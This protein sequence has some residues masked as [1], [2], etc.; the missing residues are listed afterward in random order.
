MPADTRRRR[1]FFA[2]HS[3]VR[4]LL[5]D[6]RVRELAVRIAVRILTVLLAVLRRGAV[7]ASWAAAGAAGHYGLTNGALLLLGH[8]ESAQPAGVSGG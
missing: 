2:A 7:P 3:G 4:A 5:R 8:N 6:P 1:S